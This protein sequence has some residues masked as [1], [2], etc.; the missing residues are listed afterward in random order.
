M[1]VPPGRT[2]YPSF[3]GFLVLPV[4]LAATPLRV[5]VEPVAD[6]LSH[7]NA[8]GVPEGFAVD[9]ARA[10]AADQ[11]LEIELIVKPWPQLLD[12]FRANQL[13]MLAA[14]VA[15]P[16][17]ESFIAYSAPHVDLRSAIFVRN[18]TRLP[19]APANYNTLTFGTT[20]LSAGHQYLLR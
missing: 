9:I 15:T 13:D 8:A 12:D 6:R 3:L 18:D 5:G 7:V 20:Q 16:E 17:R 1:F 10:V 14:I 4:A 2:L 11:H 19:A